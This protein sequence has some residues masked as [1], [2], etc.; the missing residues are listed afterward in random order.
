V[1]AQASERGSS[2]SATLCE[3]AETA[4]GERE[5]LLAKRMSELEGHCCRSSYFAS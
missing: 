3:Q 2:R 1:D 5:R 4:L